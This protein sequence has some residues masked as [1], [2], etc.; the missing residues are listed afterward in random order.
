MMER[1]YGNDKAWG[2]SWMVVC[3]NVQVCKETV[4]MTTLESGVLEE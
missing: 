1:G 4:N 2:S 3:S